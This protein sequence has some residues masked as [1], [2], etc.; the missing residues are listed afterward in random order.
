ML[1][2][3]LLSSCSPDALSLSAAGSWTW[4]LSLSHSVSLSAASGSSNGGG[5]RFF[6]A[7]LSL[8]PRA[9]ALSLFHVGPGQLD[10]PEWVGASGVTSSRSSVNTSEHVDTA[11]FSYPSRQQR[12]AACQSVSLALK[13]PGWSCQR[14]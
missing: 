14:K 3:V 10:V 2:A 1:C 4:L 6:L 9:R 5:R 7:A 13:P 8:P 12:T 11:F